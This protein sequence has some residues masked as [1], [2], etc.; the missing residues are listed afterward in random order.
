M[1]RQVFPNVTTDVQPNKS[2]SFWAP[3][4]W[5]LSP[6]LLFPSVTLTL[7]LSTFALSNR[8]KV[9]Y[10]AWYSKSLPFVSLPPPPTSATNSP[11]V[12]TL[13]F[14]PQDPSKYKERGTNAR[15]LTASWITH[16]WTPHGLMCPISIVLRTLHQQIEAGCYYMVLLCVSEYNHKRY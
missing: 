3:Y 12:F 1:W 15:R 8:E 11:L 13:L 10:L 4:P 9:L 7:H 5:S 6:S 16:K 2:A 14:L